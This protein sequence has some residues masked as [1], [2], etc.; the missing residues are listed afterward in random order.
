MKRALTLCSLLMLPLAG[1]DAD[2]A[3][4]LAEGATQ[5]PTA[6][7]PTADPCDTYCSSFRET[8]G[9]AYFGYASYDECE[10]L[11][12]Y[13]DDPE[14]GGN[15]A[16]KCRTG[17]LTDLDTEDPDEL[18]AGCF[19]AGPDSEVC[20]SAYVVTCERYCDVFEEGCGLHSASFESA[21]KCLSWCDGEVL[22]GD[23][24]TIECRLDWLTS[25]FAAASCADA[26]PDSG[27]CR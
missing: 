17:L 27:S 20:G 15:L 25:L 16:A 24:D 2:V 4:D 14:A 12:P 6:Q 18:A 7:P 1:C 3:F 23:G 26:G 11:C 21:S 5:K 9:G 10:Q 8:C 13:W 19:D 22:E